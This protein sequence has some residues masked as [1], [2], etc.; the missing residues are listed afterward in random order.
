MITEVSAGLDRDVF[1]PARSTADDGFDLEV[2]RAAGP[3]A[4]AAVTEVCDR[5]CGAQ[6][7]EGHCC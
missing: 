1:M 3:L 6:G 2:Q 7:L 5:C 4:M